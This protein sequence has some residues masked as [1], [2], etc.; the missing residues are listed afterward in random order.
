MAQQGLQALQSKFFTMSKRFRWTIEYV[1]VLLAVALLTAWQVTGR[2]ISRVPANALVG[3]WRDSRTEVTF[4][5]DGTLELTYTLEKKYEPRTGAYRVDFSQHPAELDIR[6]D[7]APPDHTYFLSC[8]ITSEGV[9]WMSEDSLDA[10][11]RPRTFGTLTQVY[12]R[13]PRADAQSSN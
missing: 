7:G 12:H 6:F 1:F 5:A 13:K 8:E 10:A 3:T 9:L 4:Q 2:P 11:K